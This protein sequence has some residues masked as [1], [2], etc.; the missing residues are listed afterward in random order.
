MFKDHDPQEHGYIVI[1]D[2]VDAVGELSF[3]SSLAEALEYAGDMEGKQNAVTV[4]VCM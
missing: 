4:E 2:G 1:T 3:F